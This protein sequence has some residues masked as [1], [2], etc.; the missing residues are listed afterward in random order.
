MKNTQSYVLLFTIL[1]ALPAC[2]DEIVIGTAP[3]FTVGFPTVPVTD[4]CVIDPSPWNFQ[5]YYFLPPGFANMETNPSRPDELL[6]YANFRDTVLLNGR[7]EVEVYR[8]DVKTGE[9]TYLRDSEWYTIDMEWQSDI[10]LTAAWDGQN[11]LHNLVTGDSYYPFPGYRFGDGHWMNDSLFIGRE[12]S[13]G[14]FLCSITGEVLQKI[15][16][17][18]HRFTAAFGQAWGIGIDSIYHYSLATGEIIAYAPY[19]AGQLGIY[20]L[21]YDG[22][23]TLWI[24]NTR[25]LYRFRIAEK[26]LEPFRTFECRNAR[27]RRV[28]VNFADPN[29]LYVWRIDYR[30]DKSGTIWGRETINVLDL[31]T[32]EEREIRFFE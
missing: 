32:L 27:Y 22:K 1:L 30:P 9:L 20:A 8:A 23:N 10:V 14:R 18:V 17:P 29:L 12:N 21:E 15:E 2:K 6:F 19:P 28:K 5:D 16:I 4:T 11:L 24:T 3:P 25:G 31:T 7:P 13:Q 26:E